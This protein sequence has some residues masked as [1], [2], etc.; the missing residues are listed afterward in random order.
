MTLRRAVAAETLDGLGESD[1]AAIGS[2]RDL[3]RIHRM[4]GTRGILRR[5]LGA[6]SDLGRAAAPLRVL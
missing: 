3:C 6:W 4:M 2:R 1:P 5:G